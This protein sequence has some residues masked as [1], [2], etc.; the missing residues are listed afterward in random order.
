MS[1]ET[2]TGARICPECGVP[3]CYQNEDADGPCDQWVCCGIQVDGVD[4]P[5]CFTYYAAT[6]EE[7]E[8]INPDSRR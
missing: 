6:Q 4:R 5:G 8:R 1:S 7:I 2:G 3:L